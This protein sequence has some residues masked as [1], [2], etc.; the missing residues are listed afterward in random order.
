MMLFVQILLWGCVYGLVHSYV[1]YPLLLRWAAAKK[2][3]NQL[4]HSRDEATLPVVSFIMSLY[5]EESVIEEK[6]QTLAQSRYPAHKLRIYIGSDCSS[7]ATNTQVSVW[8]KQHP[9]AHFF[10][11]EERRGKPSVINDLI[12]SAS[13][14]L[15]GQ[16]AHVLII[17][18]A[19]VLL[20]PDTIYHLAKHFKNPVIGLVD[21]NIQHPSQRAMAA[22]GIAA[23]EDHYISREVRI[24]HLE[25]RAWGRTMGPLGG[26]YAIRAAWFS[27]VPPNFLVD[28]FYIAMSVFEQ[29]GRAINELE[30][31]CYEVVSSDL[32]EEFRRK[33]RISA[34]NFAN[35][36]TFKHLLWPLTSSLSFA[37]LS[38]KVLRWLGPFFILTAYLCLWGLTLVGGNQFYGTLLLLASL[39]LFGV[40][41][42]D[43]LLKK[44]NI[45]VVLLRYITYFNAMNLAL[46]N[47]FFKYLKGVQNGIWQPTKRN[48]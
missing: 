23:S 8:A 43:G 41:V 13:D 20:E 27:P 35:L 42:L 12:S 4:L 3:N 33:T 48:S 19:N 36:A 22:E 24:K 32:K 1:V 46:F 28:D 30:A 5:N 38:H 9:Q 39:G 17:S 44:L 47:G 25:G 11:F 10:A 16:E 37:F 21:S 2:Q 40:P 26:C 14:A 7:D 15:N 18:D 34:G 45:N 6:L 29:G 31:V